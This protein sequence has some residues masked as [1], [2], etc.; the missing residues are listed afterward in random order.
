MQENDV[1]RETLLIINNYTGDRLNFG[2]AVEMASNA[3]NYNHL[4]LLIVDDDCSI[5]NPRKST[6]RRGLAGILLISKIAGAMSAQGARLNE[7]Y[8]MCSNLLVHQFIRTIG[9]C[10]RHDSSNVLTEIEIG[11][12]IHGEPGSM[13]IDRANNFKPV[14]DIMK[15]KL[16]L[17]EVK[18]DSVLLFNNL[19][20]A[21]EYAF[22]VFVKEFMEGLSIRI[23]KVYA[24]KFL[25]SLSKEAIS[26][27]IL[28]VHDPR[29]L[30]Y[31]ELP[32][33]T[34]SGDL[35]NSPFKICKPTM[36]EFLVPQADCNISNEPEVT[37]QEALIAQRIVTET[38]EATIAMKEYLN[39]IDSE[40][41]DGDTGT[42]LAEGA[43]ALI[44][45]LDEKTLNVQNPHAMLLQISSALMN[46][47]GGTSGAIFSIFFQCASTSFSTVNKYCIQNWINGLE[48]GIERVMTYGKSEFGDRTLLDSLQIGYER[49][50]ECSGST[51]E[52]ALRAFAEG[53][54]KGAEATKTM[55]PK[56]GRS[57]Y[58][59]SDKQHDFE[60]NS[61]YPDPG[62][63]A[64]S[65]IALAILRGF[66]ESSTESSSNAT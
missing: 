39:K 33:K 60:F 42:T 21:S 53:C 12:G 9:F 5:E 50:K 6:G 17:N 7:I 44:R 64:I 34:P 43:K 55:S 11:Y 23:V 8:E 41:G 30:E 18:V 63:H 45:M 51:A 29:I 27:T 1:S 36:K 49:F 56:S 3:H 38:C 2:L 48:V 15:K 66:I 52:E 13:T 24:G 65:V 31:L 58:S 10:F 14:I 54:V 62:A 47:M 46:S 4:K 20:G 59:L 40:L 28:E 32:I 26:V 37:N 61:I 35:F 22:H 25:T 19:G 57:A 16:R